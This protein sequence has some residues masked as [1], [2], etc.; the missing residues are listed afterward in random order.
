METLQRL[1]AASG[2]AEA[3][4]GMQAF[5]RTRRATTRRVP[6]AAGAAHTATLAAAARRNPGGRISLLRS[7]PASPPRSCTCAGEA[8]CS[9]GG[10]VHEEGRGRLG[11]GGG[12]AIGWWATPGARFDAPFH[13][14]RVTSAHAG[15]NRVPRPC[16]RFRPACRAAGSGL[17]STPARGR[18]TTCQQCNP[19]AGQ[20]A[21][22][23]S[24]ARGTLVCTG[25]SAAASVTTRSQVSTPASTA[26][27]P[28]QPISGAEVQG[29]CI[30]S[31]HAREGEE[32]PTRLALAAPPLRLPA[33][34][35]LRMPIARRPGRLQARP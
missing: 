6:T 27:A 25:S 23:I 22:P 7:P 16:P 1:G 14:L 29:G 8:S 5:A 31:T 12:D 35:P 26:W 9:C 28:L 33:P 20:L 19:G 11:R 24:A 2:A 17:H 4:T 10:W 30:C 3:A 21:T 34:A 13:L 15:P 18:L 32:G